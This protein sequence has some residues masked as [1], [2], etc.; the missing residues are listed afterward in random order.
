[1][2]NK[3]VIIYG[4]VNI[5]KSISFPKMIYPSCILCTPVE[6]IKEFQTLIFNFSWDGKDKVIRLSAYAPYEF[7]GLKMIDYESM[8]KALRSSWL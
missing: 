8:I 1:M 5:I 6:I 2:K 7:G 3:R 4:K